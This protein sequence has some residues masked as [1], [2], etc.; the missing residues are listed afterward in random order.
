MTNPY[1]WQL[2]RPRIELPRTEIEPLAEKLARGKSAVLLAGR[3]MGKSVFLRQLN[4]VLSR[5]DDV[6]AVLLPEPPND[7]TSRAFLGS[8][9]LALDVEVADPL[10]VRQLIEAW[11]RKSPRA[12]RLV[13]LYD[14]LDR[15]ARPRS[16]EAVPGPAD[17]SPGRELF[18][19]LESVRRDL[20]ELGM[21]AAG[22]LGVFVFRDVLGSSFLARAEA[23]RI[24]PFT[25]EQVRRLATPFADHTGELRPEVLE[26]LQLAAGGNPALTT[27]GLESLWPLADPN[28]NDV[29]RIFAR[30]RQKYGEFLRDFELSF[31]EPALSE[32]PRRVWHFLQKVR[33]P[34]PLADLEAAAGIDSGP[35]RL[36]VADVLDLLQSAGLVRVSGSARADPLVVHPIASILSLP[37]G[38]APRPRLGERL[39]SD[40]AE[41]LAS[42]HA[43]AAD[44]FCPVI[45]APGGKRLLPEAVFAAHLALGLELLGW[46]VEREAQQAAGR[47]DL[48]LRWNGGSET[49]V[50]EVKIWGRNDYR[51]AQ[52]Q[53]ESYWTRDVAAGAVVQITDAEVPDWPTDYRRTCLEGV[54]VEERS[55]EGSPIRARFTCGSTT[56]DGLETR[57]EHFLI[58]LPRRS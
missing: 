32:A 14:E 5:Q 18:N 47:S 36:T 4:G 23:V 44:F 22:N 10:S 9:A 27:Y 51:Q 35:L 25:P 45:G 34:V 54:D 41:L 1:D 26:A 50:V 7:L 31:A 6:Q 55:T 58:R 56:P 37:A 42:V 39:A 49:A 28:E 46:D 52:R 16:G 13:L 19:N 38:S 43:A 12:A 53:V 33:E 2:H 11:S 57:V 17:A 15:Y 29:A 48:K 21:L 30:F 8:L 3:G 24:R 20:P 40:L